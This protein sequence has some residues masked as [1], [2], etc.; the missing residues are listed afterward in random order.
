MKRDSHPRKR[1]RPEVLGFLGTLIVAGVA[2]LAGVRPYQHYQPMDRNPGHDGVTYQQGQTLVLTPEPAPEPAPDPEPEP[3]Q[4]TLQERLAHL[5]DNLVAGLIAVESNGNPNAIGDNGR[6]L[7]LGQIRRETALYL[8]EL[9]QGLPTLDVDGNSTITTAETH[10]VLLNPGNNR[11]YIRASLAH[12]LNLYGQWN[13]A[14]AA[15]N[16]GHS[17]PRFALGQELLNEVTGSSLDTDG[18]LDGTT[19]QTTRAFQQR[20]DLQPVDGV[21]GSQTIERLQT[22]YV[23]QHPRNADPQLRH[24]RGAVPQNGTTPGYVRRVMQLARARGN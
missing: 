23:A 8:G 21:P 13:L 17:T 12:G 14:V 22:R 19:R 11:L 2:F 15:H 10:Q 20:E 5:P 1:N 9:F 3:R 18:Q 16:A 7:G 4:P 24:A 6:S